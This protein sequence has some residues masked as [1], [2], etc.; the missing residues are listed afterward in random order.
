VE[1]SNQ[2]KC[3][4][5]VKSHLMAPGKYNCTLCAT[6]QLPKHLQLQHSIQ[7]IC[8]RTVDPFESDLLS[9]I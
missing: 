3:S 1:Q 9:L 2:L 4:T 5:Q 7:N 6:A 8:A